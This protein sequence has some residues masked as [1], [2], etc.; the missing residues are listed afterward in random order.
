MPTHQI[1]SY[2]GS[3]GTLSFLA[4]R[5]LRGDSKLGGVAWKRRDGV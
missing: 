4:L 3:H 1:K 5:F 2:R